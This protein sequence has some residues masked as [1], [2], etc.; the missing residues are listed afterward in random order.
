MD[1]VVCAPDGGWKY[2][3]KH[4]EQFPDINK[5]CNVASFWIYIGILLGAHYILHISRI[6]VN[7]MDAMMRPSGPFPPW[8]ICEMDIKFY[9]NVRAGLSV[10]SYTSNCAILPYSLGNFL[11]SCTSENFF[12]TCHS[13]VSYEGKSGCGI[14]Q[15]TSEHKRVIDIGVHTVRC[16]ELDHFPLLSCD[17]THSRPQRCD[18]VKSDM[19]WFSYN[20]LPLPAVVEECAVSLKVKVSPKRRYIP[21]NANF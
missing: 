2:H 16:T 20:I 1:T 7:R 9:R 10:Q 6:R 18:A 19:Y 4:V 21:E 8:T 11:C 5:P 13:C 12:L 17:W 14:I 15:K 3:P